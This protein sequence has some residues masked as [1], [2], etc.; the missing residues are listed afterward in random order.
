MITF[1]PILVICMLTGGVGIL[2]EMLIKKK[3]KVFLF[4]FF[5]IIV[6]VVVA[7]HASLYQTNEVLRI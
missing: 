2:F 5:L 7:G 4:L 6:V 3:N 1:K